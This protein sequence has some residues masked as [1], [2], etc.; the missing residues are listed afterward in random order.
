MSHPDGP[1]FLI[2]IDTEGDN[3]WARPKQIETRNS[4]YLPRFQELCERYGFKP[5][6]LT[7]YEMA[8]CPDFQAFA[9]DVLRCQTGEIGMHLHAWNSP[10]LAHLTDDDY[11]HQPFLIE[12]P[13]RVVREKVGFL[14]KLLEDTF[15]VKMRSH[16]AGRWAFNSLYA[17]MLVENAYDLDCSVT[18]LVSWTQTKGDPKQNGGPDYRAY[19]PG[20]YF[21]DT[22]DICRPGDSTLLETPMTIVSLMPD[23]ARRV[24]ER[25]GSGSLPG[26]LMERLYPSAAWLRPNGT[27][28]ATMLRILDQTRAE[29]RE[30]VEFMLHSSEFMPGGSPVFPTEGSIER[31]YDHLEELFEAASRTYR[32]S[33]LAEFRDTCTPAFLQ[34]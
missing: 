27:N 7:N 3:L 18:P 23:W 6:Y 2:T 13:A 17:R 12:Y 14:T 5:T 30:Y 1:F 19:P 15:G 29:S 9:T 4:K 32:G 11:S 21:V 16:R 8:Q 10:P 28:L 22:S 26:R 31:L 33:T 20:A 25:T 24:K 34:K